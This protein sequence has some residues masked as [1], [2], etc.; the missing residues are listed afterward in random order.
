M[1]FYQSIIYHRNAT[2]NWSFPVG[3]GKEQKLSFSKKDRHQKG[4]HSTAQDLIF[5]NGLQTNEPLPLLKPQISVWWR[6]L[7]ILEPHRI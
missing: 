2:A 4:L 6:L 5:I 7:T 1:T 3:K